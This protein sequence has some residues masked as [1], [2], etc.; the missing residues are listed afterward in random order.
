[1]A[2]VVWSEKVEPRLP[3]EVQNPLLRGFFENHLDKKG[4]FNGGARRKSSN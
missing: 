1:M 2:S 4:F 3:Q